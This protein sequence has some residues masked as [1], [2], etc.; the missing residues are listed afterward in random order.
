MKKDKFLNYLVILQNFILVISPYI[1]SKRGNHTRNMVVIILV[2]LVIFSMV[3][4]SK[5]IIFD[6]KILIFSLCCIFFMTISFLRLGGTYLEFQLKIYQRTIIAMI[7][8][9][10]IT[11]IDIKEKVYRYL[12]PIF[13]LCSFFPIYRGINEW[14]KSNFGANVRIFGDNWPTVFSVELGAFL[15][16]SMVVLFYDER[17]FFKITAFFSVVLGYFVI[18]GTQTRIMIVLIPFI[19]IIVSFI[20]NYKLG[21][22]LST[23]FLLIGILLGCLNFEKYF[24]RFDNDSTDGNYSNQVRIQTYKRSI[25]M[26]KE[27]KFLGVGFYNFQ[28]NSIKL[29]PSYKNYIIHE[30]DNVFVN[31]NIMVSKETL[32]IFA[33]TNSHSHNNFLEIILAQGILGFLSYIFFIYYLFRNLIRKYKKSSL[34][35][36]KRFFV[37]GIVL[38]IYILLNGLVE[39]NIYMEKV[40]QLSFFILGLALNKKFNIENRDKKFNY[41][42]E[43]K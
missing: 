30:D 15:I 40:S 17:K 7:M 1:F 21:L 4:G 16:V 37:L 31:P 25:E 11:Q 27:S 29:D 43:E 22:S 24:Q 13:S 12:L 33:C 34:Y 41:S 19:F 35:L 8:G 39:A 3:A 5:Q 14:H 18:I 9:F 32:K 28:G 42:M 23:G 36:Y 38:L 6:K 2:L 10:C 20:K 26:I